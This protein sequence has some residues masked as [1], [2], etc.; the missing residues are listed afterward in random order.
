M[1][2]PPWWEKHSAGGQDVDLEGQGPVP[3][4]KAARASPS[5]LAASIQED[6][7]QLPLRD[8]GL[9]GAQPPQPSAGEHRKFCSVCSLDFSTYASPFSSFGGSVQPWDRK[10]PGLWS[11][12]ASCICTS[13]RA[14]PAPPRKPERHS[15]RFGCYLHCLGLGKKQTYLHVMSWRQ[16]LT[17]MSCY[18]YFLILKFSQR[19]KFTFSFTIIQSLKSRRSIGGKGLSNAQKPLP[20]FSFSSVC[21]VLILVVVPW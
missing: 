11:Q 16:E 21:W 14:F 5:G 20:I 10:L 3:T 4:V 9:C 12:L 2:C 15:F 19:I 1:E 6:S 7:H 13:C 17:Q 8:A 18:L